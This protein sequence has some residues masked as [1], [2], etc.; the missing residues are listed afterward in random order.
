MHVY[1]YYMKVAA[2]LT[3]ALRCYVKT[4]TNS[5]KR[6]LWKIVNFWLFFETFS[7]HLIL[8]AVNHTRLKLVEHYKIRKRYSTRLSQSEHYF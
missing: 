3:I 2:I 6:E 1:A 8:K 5:L 7:R 4:A